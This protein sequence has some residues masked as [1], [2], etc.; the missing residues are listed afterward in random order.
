MSLRARILAVFAGSLAAGFGLFALGGGLLRQSYRQNVEDVMIDVAHLL[1]QLVE[2]DAAGGMGPATVE[3]QRV[4]TS[5]KARAI[6][7][8]IFDV[9]KGA[10]ALDVYVTDTRGIVLYSSADPSDVGR[11]FSQWRDV[12]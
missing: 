10:P 2:Q 6:Q 5:Y 11:D 12:K 3:L 9:E 8:R 7:A 4:F 1:A